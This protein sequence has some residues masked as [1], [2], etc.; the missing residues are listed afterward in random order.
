MR[1][2][3]ST[4]YGE[5]EGVVVVVVVVELMWS[6]KRGEMLTRGD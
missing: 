1:P 4:S 2:I 5:P 3:Y 6:T